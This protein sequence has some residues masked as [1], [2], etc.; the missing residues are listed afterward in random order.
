M[1]AR[2]IFVKTMPFAW[3]K[4]LLGLVFLLASAIFGAILLAVGS[5][6]GETGFFITFCIWIAVI[7]V[8]R[9]AIMHYL[10]YMLKAGHVAVITE[11]ACGGNIPQNQVKYGISKVKERFATSNIYFAV[12]KLVTAAVNQIQRAIGKVSD[13]LDFIP[14][15]D[16][17]ASLAQFFVS[18]S[19]GYVDECCLGWTFK[20]SEEGAFKSETD[21]V[22]IYAQNWKVLLK[23]AAKTMLK[24]ILLCIVAVLLIF[25]PVGL[26]FRLLNWNLLIALVLACFLTWVAKFAFLDSYIMIQMMTSYM[27]LASE[28]EIKF[29]LYGKLCGLSSKF[30]DLFNKGKEENPNAFEGE[31]AV[32]TAGAGEFT[33]ET[34]NSTQSG[35]QNVP[36]GKFCGNCGAACD[37]DTK[38][39]PSCGKKTEDLI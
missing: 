24:T 10:G 12:D 25:I 33:E 28:N 35:E 38:F 19:L 32:A 21:G 4:L 6:F 3:A 14:G 27:K 15:M 1:N 11:A 23:S 7:G 18:I 9:F 16:A 37:A 26:L 36:K 5:I 17:V 8:L 39:C 20:N 2:K 34:A 30:K 22:V 31:I 29:D 13:I